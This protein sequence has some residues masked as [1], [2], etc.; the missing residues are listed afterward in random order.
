LSGCAT[1]AK[2]LDSIDT[3]ASLY[4]M[5]YDS[6]KKPVSACV[7]SLV[8]S[9]AT[10]SASENPI[11]ATTD[12][13]GRFLFDYVAYGS[14]TLVFH[15]PDFEDFSLNFD[16][17]SKSQIVYARLT[18]Q[19]GLFEAAKKA[20]GARSWKEASSFLA[21]ADAIGLREPLSSY[22]KATL[23]YRQQDYEGAARILEALDYRDYREA[24]I[25][26]L[27]ADIYQFHLNEGAKT[28]KALRKILAL[29]E[30]TEVRA[31][32]EKLEAAAEKP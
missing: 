5:V 26:L 24:P 25:F 3:G 20:I 23:A 6:E 11:T 1:A 17:S 10:G 28:A 8:E 7:V 19:A 32:L 12:V 15:K 13:N 31:R 27:L 18:S 22:L 4:G 29:R 16:F 14:H 2:R 30:D 21:R 9:G